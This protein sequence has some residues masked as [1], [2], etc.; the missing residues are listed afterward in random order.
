[1]NIKLCSTIFT[2]GIGIVVICATN[3][4]YNFPISAQE[5]DCSNYQI[6]CFNFNSNNGFLMKSTGKAFCPKE[7][8][9]F[10]CQ[11]LREGDLKITR[12][13]INKNSIYPQ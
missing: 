2:K 13:G 4:L 1:M 8:K 7:N 6:E 5:V 9:G 12:R 11:K 3:F 10:T